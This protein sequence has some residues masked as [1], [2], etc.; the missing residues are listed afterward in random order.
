MH[1][2]TSKDRQKDAA[3]SSAEQS[4][5]SCVQDQS[6]VFDAAVGLIEQL[7]ISAVQRNLGDPAS[8]G[9]LQKTLERIVSAQEKVA[10]AHRQF[11]AQKMPPSMT[12]RNS[13]SRHEETLTRLVARIN[14]LQHVFETIRDNLSPEL[15]TDI[16]RRSMHSAYQKSL[17][18]I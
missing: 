7:E 9:Q 15:D 2:L 13:L 4:L 10:S 14:S 18:T 3:G 17:K 8:V 11:I 5:L 1:T 12:L 6:T 16:R